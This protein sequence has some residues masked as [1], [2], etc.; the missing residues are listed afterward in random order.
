MLENSKRRTKEEL[1]KDISNFLEELFQKFNTGEPEQRLMTKHLQIQ[2]TASKYQ[3]QGRIHRCIIRNEFNVEHRRYKRNYLTFPNTEIL[4]SYIKEAYDIRY[5]EYIKNKEKYWHIHDQ[6]LALR[7]KK[8]YEKQILKAK[9]HNGFNIEFLDAMPKLTSYCKKL[10]RNEFYKDLVNETYIRA[11]SIF[12]QYKPNTNMSAWLIEIAININAGNNKKYAREAKRFVFVP[13]YDELLEKLLNEPYE[14]ELREIE[15][16]IQ[17]PENT[18]ETIQTCI[19]NLS[20]IHKQHL[21]LFANGKSHQEIADILGIAPRYS[22]TRLRNIR[23]QLAK[24][25][26]LKLPGVKIKTASNK[27]LSD[28][29]L[30]TEYIYDYNE[31]YRQ[32]KATKHNSKTLIEI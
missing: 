28:K 26:E 10:C 18:I 11:E 21:M 16:E 30:N 22:I 15:G 9:L 14:L 5:I 27:S 32:R 23:I 12:N 20:E 3:I 1:L 19:E 8:K 25:I 7:K 29:K 6:I 31:N 17:Y 4:E 24:N 13:D 2:R